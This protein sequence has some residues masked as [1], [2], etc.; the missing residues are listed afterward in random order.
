M[1]IRTIILWWQLHRQRRRLHAAWPELRA[2]HEQRKSLR[3]QHRATRSIDRAMLNA[4]TERLRGEL[5]R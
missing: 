1:K 2:M 3:R 5:Q 4:T